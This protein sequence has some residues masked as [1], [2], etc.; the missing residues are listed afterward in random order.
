MA[1]THRHY[2]TNR[3][4]CQ[5]FWLCSAPPES[6]GEGQRYC[7]AQPIDNLECDECFEDRRWRDAVT[8]DAIV[9]LDEAHLS[10]CLDVVKLAPGWSNNPQAA[11][12]YAGAVITLVHATG[13]G[14]SL[15]YIRGMADYAIE[16]CN[17]Q[18]ERNA[19]G[20]LVVTKGDGK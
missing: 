10:L 19:D 18:R 20:Y 13:E 9:L 6:D 7:S 3:P 14:A 16:T 4:T 17:A 1:H 15:H 5:T 8:N 11:D 2:C 12:D